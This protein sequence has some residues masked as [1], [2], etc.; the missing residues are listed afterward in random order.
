MGFFNNIYEGIMLHCNDVKMRAEEEKRYLASEEYKRKRMSDDI[1]YIKGWV[2]FWS[3]VA[4]IVF[5]IALIQMCGT[6]MMM[7]S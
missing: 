4:I 2:R 7:P 3:W 1:H 6:M 5:F